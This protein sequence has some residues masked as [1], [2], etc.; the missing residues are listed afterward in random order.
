MDF[1]Q[2]E[3]SAKYGQG[4][5]ASLNILPFRFLLLNKPDKN[6]SGLIPYYRAT[7]NVYKQKKVLRGCKSE[8]WR[9]WWN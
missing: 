5:R 4:T 9:Y 6:Q 3:A 1:S 8:F 2:E 7:G